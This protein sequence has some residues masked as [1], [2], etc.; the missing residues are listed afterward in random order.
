MTSEELLSSSIAEVVSGEEN[1]IVDNSY[2]SNAEDNNNNVNK[3]SNDKDDWT[4]PLFPLPGISASRRRNTNCRSGLMTPLQPLLGGKGETKKRQRRSHLPP[5]I[6]G[7]SSPTNRGSRRRATGNSDSNNSYVP[8]NLL[9]GEVGLDLSR[10]RNK[11]SRNDDD[12]LLIDNNHRTKNRPS[13]IAGFFFG[14]MYEEPSNDDC[15]FSYDEDDDYEQTLSSKS[16]IFSSLNLALFASYTLTTAAATVPIVMIPQIG[17]DLLLSSS[18]SDPDL[19]SNGGDLISGAASAFSSRAA[20][21][22]VMGTACGKLL[23]GPIGDV[24]GAR[25][26]MVVYSFLLCLTL[27][28]L[29]ACGDTECAVNVCF[30]VEFFYSVIWPCSIV[31]LATHYHNPHGHNGRD[32][33]SSSSSSSITPAIHSSTTMYEGGIYLTSIASRLGSLLSIPMYSMLVRKTHWRVVCLVGAWVAM[34]GSSVVYLF[35]KDSPHNVNE[36]QN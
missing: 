16:V 13:G 17:Q 14:F 4:I 30:Y 34:I 12:I 31:V 32:Q 15:N 33:P 20:A 23:N 35:V 29:T 25:L 36:P 11:D 5:S 7:L 22:A 6:D 28:R 24:F 9:F 3:S 21:S 2:A 26:T 1:N 18:T 8:T 10:R 19:S 27:L